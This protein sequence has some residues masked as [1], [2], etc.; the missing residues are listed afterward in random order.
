MPL[1]SRAVPDTLLGTVTAEAPQA[2]VDLDLE[3][4]A[5]VEPQRGYGRDGPNCRLRG[6]QGAVD[7]VC[8]ALRTRTCGWRIANKR[9]W[10]N[11]CWPLR[12]VGRNG[13]HGCFSAET[14]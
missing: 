7:G 5:G 3:T 1:S 4:L 9:E 12:S 6:Q 13:A 14:G 10:R 8:H 11:D 2:I